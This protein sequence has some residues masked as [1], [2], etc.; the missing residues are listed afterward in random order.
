MAGI[1]PTDFPVLE[2]NEYAENTE[3]YTQTGGVNKKIYLGDLVDL[4]TQQVDPEPWTETTV[5]ISSS[6]IEILGLV[7]VQLLPEPGVN[8]YYNID[9]I[10]LEYTHNTTPYTFSSFLVV[11]DDIGYFGGFKGNLITGATNKVSKIGQILATNDASSYNISDAFAVN[12]AVYLS[13]FLGS[14]TG[15]DDAPGRRGSGRRR[16]SLSGAPRPRR[17]PPNIRAAARC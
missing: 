12:S 13:S 6:E 8:T 11:F 9:S 4:I 15:G 17:P 2:P 5:D 14:P 3:L 1:K 16:P 7:V 10:I